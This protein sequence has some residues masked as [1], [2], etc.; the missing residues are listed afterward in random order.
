MSIRPHIYLL[1]GLGSGLGASLRLLLSVGLYQ[2]ETLWP[3]ATLLA[4]CVGSM[5]MGFYATMVSEQGTWQ[6]SEAQKQFVLA[7]LCGGFTTFSVFSLECLWLQQAGYPGLAVS[8]GGLSLLT[9]MI[10][11]FAGYKL[12]KRCSMV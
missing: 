3:W 2:P 10:A 12:A 9:W 4:N 1:V 6:V 11:V 8:Y 7:G 5:A